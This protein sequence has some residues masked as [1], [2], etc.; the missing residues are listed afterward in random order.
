M[1]KIALVALL[2]AVVATP[3][4]A[5][6]TGK[7]YGAVDLGAVSLSNTNPGGTAFGNPGAFR[8]VGG[9]HINPMFAVEAGYLMMGDS[10]LVG[11]GATATSK[12]SALQFAAVGSYPVAPQF[13]LIGKLGLSMNSNKLAGTGRSAALN[14]SNTTT[15]LMYGI[16]GQY[17]VNSQI[18]IRAQYES[19]GNSK[20]TNNTSG[21]SLDTSSTMFSVGAAYNF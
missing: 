3:A 13:D 5:D 9:Y 6:N 17:N 7:F 18:S 21:Q 14:S 15:S 19:F 16:G 1:K 12:N 8:F 4:L 20:T 11:T 2:S 10:T